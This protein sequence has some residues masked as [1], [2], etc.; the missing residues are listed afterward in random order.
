MAKREPLDIPGDVRE[1]LIR[2]SRSRSESAARVRRA[3]IL[4]AYSDGRRI[5]EIAKCYVSPCER[6][7]ALKF[8]TVRPD[9]DWNIP[10]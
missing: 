10:L 5:S 7:S 9:R 4:L 8:P 6:F 3:R 1:K 2:I